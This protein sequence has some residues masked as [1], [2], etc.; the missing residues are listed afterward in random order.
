MKT[1]LVPEW[2]VNCAD[3]ISMAKV[4]KCVSPLQCFKISAPILFFRKKTSQL[5]CLPFLQNILQTEKQNHGSFW[6]ITSIRFPVKKESM[7]G[8]LK[9]CNR[10]C[11]IRIFP[12]WP[13]ICRPHILTSHSGTRDVF[14]CWHRFLLP[15]FSF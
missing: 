5:Y 9:R 3:D 1:S 6:E 10:I 11:E 12:L 2:L 14:I 15:D 4:G 8:S 13:S 7:A